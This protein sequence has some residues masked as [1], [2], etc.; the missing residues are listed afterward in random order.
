[1]SDHPDTQTASP[2]YFPFAASPPHGESAREPTLNKETPHG[3][4]D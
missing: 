1:M 2:R 3:Q 4:D